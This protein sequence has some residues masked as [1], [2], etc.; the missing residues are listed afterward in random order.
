MFRKCL[1]CLLA[2][3]LA[4]TCAAAEDIHGYN[5]KQGGYSYVHFG[6]FPQDAQGNE[7]P[8]LWRVLEV[9]ENEA[10]LLAE[11]IIDVHYVHLDTKAYYDMKWQESDLYA[12]LQSDFMNRAFT[13]AEQQVLLQ[14]TEDGALVTL[15]QIDDIRNKAY[16]FADNKSREC[17]GT[18]YAK[19]IGL[20]L[21]GDKN[22]PWISRNKSKDRPQQQRRVMD[23]GKLGTVPCGNV[24]LGIRPCVYV[25]LDQLIISGGTG[26]KDDPF[27]LVSAAAPKATEIPATAVPATE[28]PVVVQPAV[29]APPAAVTVEKEEKTTVTIIPEATVAPASATVSGSSDLSAL[30]GQYMQNKGNATVSPMTVNTISGP[31]MSDMTFTDEDGT[32][33]SY[34]AADGTSMLTEA[35]G[36]AVITI[37][38]QDN[39]KPVSTEEQ[40]EKPAASVSGFAAGADPTWIHPSF[41][42]L[43]ANGF[44]PE[45]AAEFVL[46]DSENGLW[47]YA[48]Q[49]LRIQIERKVG[50][51]SKKQPLRWYE[52]RIFTRDESEMF[53][54]YPWD[55]ENY[56]NHY[57][58]TLA[59]EIAL[60]HKL[61]FAINSDYF[62][63]REARQHD[64]D[65]NYTY[66]K[67]LIIRD[68]EVFYDLP[69][70]SNSTVYPPL[71]VLAFYPDGDMKV[72]LNGSMTADEMLKTGVTDTL[73]FGPILVENGEV[74]PRSTEFGSTP[75]P[76][77]AIGM[78]EKGHYVCLMAESR[79]SESKG[80]SCVW[81]GKKMEELGCDVA[82][83]LDGGATSTMIFMGKQINKSGNYGDI[84]NRKQNE[85]IGIGISEN[86]GK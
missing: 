58:L 32:V 65:V 4:V 82:L 6:T 50:T 5:K 42:G 22:S 9:K 23:E 73:S 68:R 21:Y 78:V 57:K 7:A 66:P 86:V 29:T 1:L 72:F 15:P 63:Y 85:L 74:S 25:D 54:L 17:K 55:E 33:I 52:A 76:R 51:N 77:T 35:S 70:N 40:E 27:L 14:R 59:D 80:E 41:E 67:G 49:T 44:L 48:S 30:I 8:I 46:E 20:Y 36:E 34:S 45:G 2:L 75:N 11:Y 39:E 64:K 19:S 83:N 79:I 13:D 24:D 71:D 61:V 81:M 12:Y 18:D 84:T 3:L 47:L 62:I 43:A 10:Y 16:G 28:A 53:D 31:D 56:K 38:P 26:V 60:K 69:R 37:L